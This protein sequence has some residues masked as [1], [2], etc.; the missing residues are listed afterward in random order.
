AS[1]PRGREPLF[2]QTAGPAPSEPEAELDAE[3]LAVVTPGAP[4]PGS[5]ATATDRPARS[6]RAWIHVALAALVLTVA[7]APKPLVIDDP[8]YVRLAQQIAAEPGDPYGI[9]LE[10]P[11]GVDPAFHVVGP[12]PVL[13]Y[14]LA[15][16]MALFGDEPWRWKLALLPF[17]LALAASLHRLFER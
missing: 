17:A 11:G 2:G 13:P 16:S 3:I 14:W 10:W 6:A 9:E 15:G 5:T 7:N 8:T 12:M 4:N 1:N